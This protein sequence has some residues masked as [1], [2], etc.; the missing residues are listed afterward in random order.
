MVLTMK[1]KRHVVSV[2][3]SW[4]AKKEQEFNCILT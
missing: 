2:C 3:T 4:L 1:L